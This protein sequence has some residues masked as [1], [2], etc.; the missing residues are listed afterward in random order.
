MPRTVEF[1]GEQI[2]LADECSEWALMEFADT[3]E[4]VESESL[5]ALAATMRLLKEAVAPKDWARFTATARKHKAKAEQCLPVVVAVFEG[6]TDRP[7]S[8]PADSLA[9][10]RTTEP[11]SP[12][13][14]SSPAT[15]LSGR[16]DLQLAV[17]RAQES[18][19]S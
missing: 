1:F 3:A 13:G 11:N 17:L 12:A 14:S 19:A 9:G 10:Q 2:E 5:P 18:R 6:A 8:L 4:R 7:T 15:L 16:P